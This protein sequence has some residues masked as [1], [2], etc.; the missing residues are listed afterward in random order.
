VSAEQ[1]NLPVRLI[2]WRWLPAPGLVRAVAASA[3]ARQV[4]GTSA[5]R[6]AEV[7][8]AVATSV[9]VTRALGPQGRGQY[10]AVGV[11]TALGVQ[12]GHLGLPSAN[13]YLAARDRRLLPA[14][15]AN[16]LLVGLGLGGLVACAVGGL[17]L[18]QP[19]LAPASPAL[20]TLALAAI[21]VTLCH[22]LLHNLLMG[23]R[24]VGLYNALTLVPAGLF[25]GGVVLLWLA[26]ALT[27]VT[28]CAA[29]LA[30]TV[31][32]GLIA[33]SR[34]LRLGGT[35][36]SPSWGLVLTSATYGVKYYVVCL[37]NALVLRAD[38]VLVRY[39]LGDE[40]AGYYAVAAGFA[41]WALLIPSVWGLLLV[42]NLAEMADARQRRRAWVEATPYF[43]LLMAAVSLGGVLLVYPAVLVLYGAAFAPSVPAYLCLAPG[44]FF[45]GA[46]YPPA[47][48]LASTGMT[49]GAVL[50]WLGLAAFNLGLNVVIIPRAGVVGAALVSSVTYALG[51]ALFFWLASRGGR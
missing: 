37:C 11:L 20:L 26:A 18:L 12:L 2:G 40:R 14:L 34:L 46:C 4:V 30:G 7:L 50:V 10:A 13:T 45:W 3:F 39:Y 15:T 21:P 6:S 35:P 38:L 8:L 27:P 17:T 32:A 22:L 1:S 9:L 33:W 36:G 16:S 49:A 24:Q 43:F 31:P 25:F 48:Y 47:A 42:P 29:G 19:G 23:C 44:V 41:D 51:C 28:A 5:A